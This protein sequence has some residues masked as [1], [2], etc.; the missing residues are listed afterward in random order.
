MGKRTKSLAGFGVI[1]TI[2]TA[3]AIFW[4]S[5][6][7]PDEFNLALDKRYSGATIVHTPEHVDRI[8]VP[9]FHGEVSVYLN[10]KLEPVWMFEGITWENGRS[11]MPNLSNILARTGII[12]QYGGHPDSLNDRRGRVIDEALE[13]NVEVEYRID[14]ENAVAESNE[15]DNT[16]RV[17]ITNDQ[18][19]DALN[20]YMAGVNI[21]LSDRR[22][23]DRV[24][25]KIKE[26]EAEGYSV[27]LTKP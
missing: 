20:S 4:N 23:T 21:R 10:G 24:K 26:L 25:R 14:T 6:Q 15:Q 18:M 7:L 2:A 27:S 16:L 19:V 1:G 22:K 8:K 11:A 9:H 5:R 12:E 3:G 17:Q 13:G